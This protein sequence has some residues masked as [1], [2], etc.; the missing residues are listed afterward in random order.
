M[1]DP[2]LPQAWRL[3]LRRTGCLIRPYPM[4]GSAIAPKLRARIT[5]L[6]LLKGLKKSDASVLINDRFRK[7][8][9]SSRQIYQNFINL[10]VVASSESDA[11]E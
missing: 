9:T 4:D 10:C 6:L 1:Q 5:R 2:A 8:P 3:K 11:A 7:F